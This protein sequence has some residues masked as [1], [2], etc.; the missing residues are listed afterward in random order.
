IP[1][2]K[3]SI[4]V[5]EIINNDTLKTNQIL[6]QIYRISKYVCDDPFLRAQI[7]QVFYQ[8]NGDFVVIPQVGSQKIIF[9][10]A[11]SEDDVAKKF[12]KLIVFYQ[13]GMPYEGWNTY[14]EINLKYDKQ[15]V[16]RKKE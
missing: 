15:I 8:K 1:D 14:E 10:S 7:G 11:K 2:R 13:E 16:C 9:G 4:S 6:D 5:S 3:N 12:K